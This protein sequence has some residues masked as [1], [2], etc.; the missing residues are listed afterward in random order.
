MDI[1]GRKEQHVALVDYLVLVRL[2]SVS[3]ERRIILDILKDRPFYMAEDFRK[4]QHA[5]GV[6]ISVTS[7]RFNQ[8]LSKHTATAVLNIK[9]LLILRT[10]YEKISGTLFYLGSNKGKT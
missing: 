9:R 4:R 6:I 2:L 5:V 1:V 3:L 8:F 10:C 7:Q